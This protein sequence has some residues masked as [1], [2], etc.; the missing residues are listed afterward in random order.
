MAKSKREQREEYLIREERA[1]Y[2]QE[3]QF[4]DEVVHKLYPNWVNSLVEN[5]WP[6]QNLCIFLVGMFSRLID[7]RVER[8][9]HVRNMGSK[10]V[11]EAITVSVF[12][13]EK[14]LDKRRIPTQY[15][16]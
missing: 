5:K 11:L 16:F 7:I 13:G 2:M 12:Q 6:L 1:Y 15:I 4:V 10:T 9:Q 8:N 3:A 14:L